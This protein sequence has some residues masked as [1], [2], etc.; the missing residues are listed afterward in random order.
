MSSSKRPIIFNNV[1]IGA[2]A[3]VI[4]S[5]TVGHHSFVGANS[6]VITDVPSDSLAVGAPARIVPLSK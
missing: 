2:G 3:V 5:I 4:G 1:T 6:V